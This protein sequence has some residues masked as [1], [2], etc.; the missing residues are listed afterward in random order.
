MSPQFE[1]VSRQY[2]FSKLQYLKPSS[3]RL[4][5]VD[6]IKMLNEAGENLGPEDDIGTTQEKL[7]GRIVKEKYNTDFFIVDKFPVQ[8][9]PFYTMPDPSN[10]KYSNSY[11]FFYLRGEEILSGSQRVHD[12]AFLSKNS[13]QKG[14]A[15]D[16]IRSYVDSFKYG[17]PPHAG[18]GIGLERV[19]MLYL[20]LKNIRHT[21]MFPRDPSRLTP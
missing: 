13:Q 1:A 8:L 3:L 21:T 4:Q 10:P 14:V 17:A 15:V 7:L 6:A 2:P 18:G 9:R 20:G 16:S 5:Y 11:E 12:V 19:A